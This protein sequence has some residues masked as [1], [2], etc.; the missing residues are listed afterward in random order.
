MSN[1]IYSLE[2]ILNAIAITSSHA[3]KKRLIFDKAPLGGLGRKWLIG[4]F[5]LFPFILYAM[6]FNDTIFSM[7]GIAQ[8]IV[9]YIVMLSMVMLLIFTLV[10]LNN[11]SV[12]NQIKPSWNN[13]FP[14]IEFELITTTGATPYK[15]F[16]NYYHKNITNTT[17][18]QEEIKSHLDKI[19]EQMQEE[20]RDLIEAMSR[21]KAKNK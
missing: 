17:P 14:T 21:D 18:T 5:W 10:V 12:I 19:F 8:A 20:N 16:F 11:S 15:E 9:I 7:L 3:T 13:Y 6:I 4:L 2:Q 1:T